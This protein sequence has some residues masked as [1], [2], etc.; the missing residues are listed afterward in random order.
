MTWLF[1]ARG[2][3]AQHQNVTVSQCLHWCIM[4]V[5]HW[6]GACVASEC[7]SYDRQLVQGTPLEQVT[8]GAGF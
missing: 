6:H 3:K 7:N 4:C 2:K 8:F 5:C 1:R